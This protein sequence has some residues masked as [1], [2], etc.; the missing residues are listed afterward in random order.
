MVAIGPRPGSTP[1]S[2]PMTVP[3]K[4]YT[5]FIGIGIVMPMKFSGDSDST[6]PNPVPRFASSVSMV[7]P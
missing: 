6:A 5:K 4:Q 7:V 2:V 3:K 1:I